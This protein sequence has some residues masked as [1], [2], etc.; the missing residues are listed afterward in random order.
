MAH[1]LTP[2]HYKKGAFDFELRQDAASA[3]GINKTARRIVFDVPTFC[4]D[5][6]HAAAA[7]LNDVELSFAQDPEPPILQ[8]FKGWWDEGYSILVSDS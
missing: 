7:F 2:G 3:H 4:D 5:V 1:S 8:N 6:L